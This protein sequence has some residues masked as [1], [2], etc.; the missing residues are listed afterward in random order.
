MNIT[1]QVW[2]KANTIKNKCK[3]FDQCR[4]LNLTYFED[5]KMLDEINRGQRNSHFPR[6][7]TR[8]WKLSVLYKQTVTTKNVLV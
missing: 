4:L 5:T 7:E 8:K 3:A 2:K 1:S 6:L